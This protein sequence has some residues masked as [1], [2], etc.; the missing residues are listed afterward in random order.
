MSTGE[1]EYHRITCH[2][3]P[4]QSD[5]AHPNRFAVCNASP[6]K[7]EGV[8]L[9]LYEIEYQTDL[10]K[11]SRVETVLNLEKLAAVM[12]IGYDQVAAIQQHSEPE[13]AHAARAATT[14][15]TTLPD[16][17]T[18]WGERPMRCIEEFVQV[19][20]SIDALAR[21][22]RAEL[23]SQ[24]IHV[25][26]GTRGRPRLVLLDAITWHLRRA[27]FTLAEIADLVPDGVPGNDDPT[28]AREAAELR[29]R[30]RAKNDDRRYAVRF[31]DWSGRDQ[32]GE[33]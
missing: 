18:R 21:E 28:I 19:F 9:A 4:G 33:S 15:A 32:Q 10:R 11:V 1:A 5:P 24:A 27:G 3:I 16:A 12:R 30:Y 23:V 17:A 8:S 13:I 26:S 25:P 29:V 22:T 6:C 20:R 7:I 14:S 2:G 31:E